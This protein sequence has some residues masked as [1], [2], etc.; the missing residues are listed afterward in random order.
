M[1]ASYGSVKDF[2]SYSNTEK[3][4]V[5]NL[6]LKII[7]WPKKCKDFTA[8]LFSWNSFELRPVKLREGWEPKSGQPWL[9]N[10]TCMQ[11]DRGSN[12]ESQW[13]RRDRHTNLT[14]FWA[15][16]KLSP[17]PWIV[18]PKA[19]DLRGHCSFSLTWFCAN[20]EAKGFR[21]QSIRITAF[22]NTWSTFL[23]V[24]HVQGRF[25]ATHS[26]SGHGSHITKAPS[27]DKILT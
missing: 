18:E 2:W 6:N 14:R 7:L 13:W 1:G 10:T 8:E 17:W 20:I 19:K 4:Q 11:W 27:S 16:S 25:I 24:K 21:R 3:H 26:C 9:E 12:P 15:P 5:T 23:P 22:G